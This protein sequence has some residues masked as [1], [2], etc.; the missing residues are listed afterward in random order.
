MRVLRK[1]ALKVISIIPTGTFES[2]R[3]GQIPPG[4][5]H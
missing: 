3:Q 1:L 4:T 5:F 2:G